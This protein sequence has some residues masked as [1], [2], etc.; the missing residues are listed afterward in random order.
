M[1]E[2]LLKLGQGW[3]ELAL[4]LGYSEVEVGAVARAGGGDP[5]RQLLMFLR[6]WWIPDCG[7]LV[8]QDL[9]D[10]GSVCY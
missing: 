8:T 6:V 2:T 1:Y 7:R 10:K 3:R 9:L 5:G 4:Y